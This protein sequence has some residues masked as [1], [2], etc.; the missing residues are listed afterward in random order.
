MTNEEIADLYGIFEQL[1]SDYHCM[2]A[3]G[4]DVRQTNVRLMD[5]TGFVLAVIQMGLQRGKVDSPQH[6]GGGS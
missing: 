4:A 6:D 1:S 5:R 3:I 2:I